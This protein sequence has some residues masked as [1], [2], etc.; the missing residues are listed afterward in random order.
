MHFLDPKYLIETFGTIGLILVIYAESGIL[1]GLVFPGDSLLFTAGLLASQNKYGLNIFFIAGGAFAGAVLGAQTGYWLGKRFGPSLFHRPDSRIFKQEYVD[2]SKDYFDRYGGKTVVIGRFVPFVRTLVPMLAG[3][4]EMD[5]GAFTI[6]NVIGAALWAAGVS[7]AGYFL[8]KSI[9]NVDH[10]LL[11]IIGVIILISVIPPV[12][13]IRRQRKT[14]RAATAGTS[15]VVS[16]D[17]V[18]VDAEVE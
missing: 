14:S 3:I 16:V 18:Q 11:P 9:P 2:K 8:G 15:P 10:Y 12:L 1:L 17:A 4:G 6:F 5:L 7:V 13:E